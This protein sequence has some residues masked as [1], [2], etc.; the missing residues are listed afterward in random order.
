M[1]LIQKQRLS[2]LPL[3]VLIKTLE[4]HE[5]LAHR[6]PV[7]FECL[8]AVRSL[9]FEG[10]EELRPDRV[11]KNAIKNEIVLIPC[12][13]WKRRK[14]SNGVMHGERNRGVPCITWRRNSLA[15]VLHEDTFFCVIQVY[16]NNNVLPWHY[17]EA[18]ILRALYNLN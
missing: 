5:Y 11:R 10:R 16:R 3:F 14:E 18:L 2:P 4:I 17:P 13:T 9:I 15:V 7:K 8:L 6:L 12:N 1:L